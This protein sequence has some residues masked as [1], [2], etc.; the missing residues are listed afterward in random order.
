MKFS[1]NSEKQIYNDFQNASELYSTLA[2]NVNEALITSSCNNEY[3][4]NFA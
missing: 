3:L 2:V 4:C 1:I